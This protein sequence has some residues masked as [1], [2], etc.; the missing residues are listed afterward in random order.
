MGDLG[1]DGQCYT[2]TTTVQY[3]L[4]SPNKGH[5][6]GLVIL[7]LSVLQT[8][9]SNFDA[10]DELELRHRVDLVELG[11]DLASVGGEG[12]QHCQVRERHQGN[13]VL[14]V[15]P[16]LGVGDQV[17]SILWRE[18]IRREMFGSDLTCWACSLVG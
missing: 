18:E 6:P 3:R 10:G 9:M 15:G 2:S 4:H 5:D 11:E 1:R 17:D 8:E 16:G 7:A 12:H 14:R 13:V